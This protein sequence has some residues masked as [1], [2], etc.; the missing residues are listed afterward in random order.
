MIFSFSLLGFFFLKK[1]DLGVRYSCTRLS[2]SLLWRSACP[3]VLVP[4]KVV[5][6]LNMNLS[7][8]HAHQGPSSGRPDGRLAP[9]TG[10]VCSPPPLFFLFFHSNVIFRCAPVAFAEAEEVVVCARL[11]LQ[12]MVSGSSRR[13]GPALSRGGTS[14]R[15]R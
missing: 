14:A 4:A 9:E 13:A 6:A 3:T 5:Q 12:Q 1:V 11:S 8:R 15:S 7:S 10:K 2:P